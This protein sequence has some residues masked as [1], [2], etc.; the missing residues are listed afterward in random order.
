MEKP[1]CSPWIFKFTVSHKSG[2]TSKAHYKFLI[3]MPNCCFQL[4]FNCLL[5]YLNRQFCFS[6]RTLRSINFWS[7]V[8]RL[9]HGCKNTESVSNGVIFSFRIHNI[10]SLVFMMGGLINLLSTAKFNVFKSCEL[11]PALL[12]Q[13]GRK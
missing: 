4:H 13:W 2:K 7:P 8:C 10:Y 5:A 3:K 1:N 6:G 11:T 12:I 9:K